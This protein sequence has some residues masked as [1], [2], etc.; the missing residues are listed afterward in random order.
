MTEGFS[1]AVPWRPDDGG[2][3]DRIWSW[4]SRRWEALFPEAEI[5]S[6]DS[7]DEPFSRGKS[8]NFAVLDCTEDLIVI[9]DADTV[10]DPVWVR[11]GL[12]LVRAGAPWV[13]CYDEGRYYNATA[14]W[15]AKILSRGPGCLVAEPAEGRYEHKITAWS[16]ML[17]V[18]RDQFRPFDPRF[19]GWGYED[20][21]F[22]TVMDREIGPH[23]RVPGYVVHLWHPEGPRFDQP[24]IAHNRTILQRIQRER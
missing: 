19:V 1:V 6:A 15:T 8:L 22:M 16:G 2:P 11:R 10:P 9:A 3:R 7:G 21:A 24:H 14:E 20:N 5:V 17:V 23:Q 18:R 12:A 4:I 13:I